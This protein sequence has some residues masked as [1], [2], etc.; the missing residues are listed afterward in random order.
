MQKRIKKEEKQNIVLRYRMANRCLHFKRDQNSKK[1]DLSMD[2]RRTL[3]PYKK[4][5]TKR[6]FKTKTTI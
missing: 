4:N 2:T 6:L 5:A 3:E 1:Y